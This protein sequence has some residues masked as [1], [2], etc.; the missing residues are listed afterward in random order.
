GDATDSRTSVAVTPSV[1]SVAPAIGPTTGGTMVVITGLGFSG[2]DD[3]NPS[4]VKFG[5]L[6]AASFVVNSN[7]QITAVVPAVG[8]VQTV[9]VTLTTAAGPSAT[10]AAD[11]FTY[12]PA[13]VP[14]N[15]STMVVNGG[16]MYTVDAFGEKP[17][18]LLGNNS[19][20]EQLYVTF[21]IGVTLA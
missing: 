12:S 9:D 11:Q 5:T 1:T 19:I 16:D 7:T 6:D 4:S 18:A 13:S 8:S 10:S 2:V 20:V 3:S 21:D 15:F 17:T 14:P